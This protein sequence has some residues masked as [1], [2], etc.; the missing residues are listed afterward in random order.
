MTEKKEI[1]LIAW[2][3]GKTFPGHIKENALAALTQSIFKQLQEQ[4]GGR[5]RPD[6]RSQAQSSPNPLFIVPWPILAC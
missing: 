6:L 1:L 2:Q 5:E 4:A 3:V